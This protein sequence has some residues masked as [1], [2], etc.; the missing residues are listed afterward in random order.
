M[1]KPG[2]GNTPGRYLT[3][4]LRDGYLSGCGTGQ[5]ASLLFDSGNVGC[6]PAMLHYVRQDLRTIQ[7]SAERPKA[8]PL[9][10]HQLQLAPFCPRAGLLAIKNLGSTCF[11]AGNDSNTLRQ[12][13]C[14]DSRLTPHF[15]KVKQ[16]VAL[17]LQA[18][19]AELNLE[20]RK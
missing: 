5:S 3:Y 9:A 14:F 8:P 6:S 4:F 10:V 19:F 7:H 2:A 13:S 18:V 11:L 17:A 1:F 20:R 15:D 12:R 16:P